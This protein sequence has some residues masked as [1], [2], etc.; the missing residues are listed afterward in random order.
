MIESVAGFISA[1]PMPCT[2]RAPIRKPA[3][4][5][6]PQASDASVKTTSPTMNIF[7]RP[8]MSPSLPPVI[9]NAANVNAYAV[10][11]HSSD[12][13]DM[14]RLCSIAGSATFTI[15]LSSMIM[16]RPKATAPSVHHFLFSSA[17][18]RAFIHCSRL[19]STKLVDARLAESH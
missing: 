13:I 7:R 6:S 3:L 9:S 14:C 18:I 8:N 15:V 17:K 10:T 12:E 1:A 2:A 19:V 5:A 16:K 11:I 4:G